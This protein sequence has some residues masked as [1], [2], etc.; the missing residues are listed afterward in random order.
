MEK[1]LDTVK[2]WRDGKKEPIGT[3]ELDEDNRCLFFQIENEV[4][5]ERVKR[6]FDETGDVS[7]AWTRSDGAEWQ[8]EVAEPLTSNWFIFVVVNRLSRLGYRADFHSGTEK[9]GTAS[10]VTGLL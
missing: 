1:N 10:Q 7:S 5:R 6:I 9:R 3:V 4:D 2:L 8:Q